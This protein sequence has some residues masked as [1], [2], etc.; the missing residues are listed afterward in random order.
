MS[1]FFLAPLLSLFSLRFYRRLLGR[2]QAAGF[3]YL[4]YL[5]LLFSLLGLFA[6][7]FQFV[8]V[9]NDLVDWAAK[10]IPE[11][12]FTLEGVQMK[13]EEPLLLTHPRWGPLLY[14][15]PQSDFPK[16]D[17]LGKA[18]VIVT[19]TKVAYRDPRGG[20]V[21]IQ[22]LVPAERPEKWQNLVVTGER[23]KRVWRQMRPWT[24]AIF[25]VSLFVGIYL[26]KLLAGLFYS[27]VGLIL[28]LFRTERLR[29]PS[30]LNLSFFVLT[31]VSLLQ[32]L[33]WLF[34]E[35]PIPLNFLTA[36][37]V[38]SLYLTLTLLLTQRPR[39]SDTTVGPQS[40]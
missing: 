1:D 21:R 13:I 10:S 37:L 29:Y 14:L 33:T 39:A 5:S 28:N 15:D 34:P 27:L 26:W 24:G 11:T 4:A 16:P 35:W 22:E 32:I 25:F 9:A 23:I 8:P 3:L 17:D 30:I 12:T 2:S 36:L 20:E 6:F 19:R 40:S 31:P 38:T 18:L 7:R